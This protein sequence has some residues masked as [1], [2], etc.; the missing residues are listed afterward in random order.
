MV[1][2]RVSVIQLVDGS[3][4]KLKTLQQACI[5]KFPKS[6]VDGRGAD[7]VICATAWQTVNQLVSIKVVVLLEDSLDEKFSLAGLT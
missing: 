2:L 1:V 5:N 6:S 7:V 3:P 4:V